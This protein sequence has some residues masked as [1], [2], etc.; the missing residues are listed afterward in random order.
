MNKE[1]EKISET[2][3]GNRVK[4]QN[5]KKEKE[6]KIKRKSEPREKIICLEVKEKTR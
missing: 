6:V 4:K 3:K 5:I 1:E 2:K